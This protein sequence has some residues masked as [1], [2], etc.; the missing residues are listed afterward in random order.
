M[1]KK[2]LALLIVFIAAI[3]I[4]NI[5]AVETTNKDF[6]E[7]FKMDVP[8]SENFTNP[9]VEENQ[10]AP[11]LCA[12]VQFDG[13]NFTIYYYNDSSMSSDFDAENITD[14]L[15]QMLKSNSMYLD[16]PEIDGN[17]YIWNNSIKGDSSSSNYLVGISSEDAT[18]MVCLEGNN[19]DD[20]KTYANTVKFE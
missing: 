9:C 4:A 16:K 8:S 5:Y 10:Y 19:L 18:Q 17:L 2:I 3:S 20:L 11:D 6:D 14:Y 7:L 13:E 15:P 12:N 1:N